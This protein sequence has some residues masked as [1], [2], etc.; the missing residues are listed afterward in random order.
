MADHMTDAAHDRTSRYQPRRCRRKP[1]ARCLCARTEGE[2][3]QQSVSLAPYCLR[4]R[5]KLHDPP[6]DLAENGP[7]LGQSMA[8]PTLIDEEWY[9]AAND[10]KNTDVLDEWLGKVDQ[11]LIDTRNGVVGISWPIVVAGIFALAALNSEL[12]ARW[13]ESPLTFWVPFG[14]IAGLII[15]AIVLA[16]QRTNVRRELLVLRA[17]YLRRR[18]QIVVTRASA[19]ESS[20]REPRRPLLHW[21]FGC[22][23]LRCRGAI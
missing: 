9:P 17:G 4:M 6:P 21:L 15:A 3:S 11:A 8:S 10:L 1:S 12:L 16:N 20:G 2:R 19:P 23:H 13:S 14:L 7:D 22:A 18:R 5:K